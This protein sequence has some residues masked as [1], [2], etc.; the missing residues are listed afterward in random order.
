M[1]PKS[2]GNVSLATHTTVK[3]YQ[4]K[5]R[6]VDVSGIA[7]FVDERFNERYLTPLE[8]KDAHGFAIMATCCLLIEVLECFR[9]GWPE[10]ARGRG[11]DLFRTFFDRQ[12]VKKRFVPLKGKGADFYKHVRCGILHQG[13][14]TGGWLI[15]RKNKRLLVGKDI[16]ARRFQ[17][18]MTEALKDY[19]EELRATPWN[20]P[21][22][23]AFR[24]K[25]NAVI[26][27]VLLARD[28]V[29]C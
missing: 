28:A 16:N 22:W 23:T 4:E 6:K 27:I 11:S 8:H 2:S 14:T 25:M 5:E 12:A 26:R 24:Y 29:D 18:Q 17:Q 10:T 21:L 19:C 13:E 20:D 1:N 15:N 9:N 3:Q 7:D